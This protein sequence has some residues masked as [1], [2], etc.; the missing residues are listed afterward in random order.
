MFDFL[1]RHRRDAIRQEPFPPSFR[2][3]LDAN[4]PHFSQLS[5]AEQ[6]ELRGL[7]LVFL[8][9]KGFEGA[10]GLV[11]TDEI[12]VTIA[13]EA[14]LLLL[15]RESDIYPDLETIVVYP[16][17]YRAKTKRV[18]AGVV[19]EGEEGRL[20]ESWQ[21]GTVVL[22][23][24]AVKRGAANIFDGHNVAL[25]EFAHQLDGE[26]GAMNG[27]PELGARS[28]YTAW[29]RVL[30]H[31]FEE[32][33]ERVHRGRP[34]DIDRYG[35]TNPPEFFAVVTELFFEKPKQ[36]R[37]KHPELYEQLRAFYQQDPAERA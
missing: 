37:K 36:L 15:H 7:I 11:I 16:T 35:S 27:T 32:L 33:T 6:T 17:A 22:T 34:S 21:R 14:C 26:D 19:F 10:A 23:W 13:A 8:E 9:E 4:V 24:D 5:P 30:S 1:R 20:G 18:E 28:R 31:E 29:G 3:I 25:H 12:R 2:A